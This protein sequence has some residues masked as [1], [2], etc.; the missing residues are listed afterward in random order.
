ASGVFDFGAQEADVVV[1][2]IIVGADQ[3]RR[4]QSGEE[5]P[6]EMEGA[7]RKIEGAS[8]IKVSKSSEDDPDQSSH[9]AQPQPL[10]DPSDAADAAIKQQRDQQAG[11]DGDAGLAGDGDAKV[12]DMQIVDEKTFFRGRPKIGGVLREP[13]A[14]RGDGERGAERKLPHEEEREQASEAL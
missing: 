2:P 11:S 4:A 13:D 3:Q 14:S 8:G 5:R 1:A 12:E 6:P 7:R 9:D 10:R